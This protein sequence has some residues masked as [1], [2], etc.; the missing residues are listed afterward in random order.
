MA[1]DAEYK[2][3]LKKISGNIRR[4][5]LGIGK[6]Q[7]DMMD[8]G[9]NYRFYQKL[10]SGSHSLNLMTLYKLAMVF[11]VPISELLE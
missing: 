5:R 10:E 1:L 3:L 7:E 9:F 2:R 11:K 4:L 8:Y 6:T